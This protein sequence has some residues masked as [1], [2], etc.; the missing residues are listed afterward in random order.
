MT[1][2]SETGLSIYF[3]ADGLTIHLGEGHRAEARVMRR[4]DRLLVSPAL[5]ASNL[6]R[7]QTRT[8]FELSPDEQLARF[9]KIHFLVGEPPEDFDPLV[10]GSAQAEAAYET[11]RQRLWREVADDDERRVLLAKLR[12]RFQIGTTSRTLKTYSR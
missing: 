7:D 12:D 5:R 10:P 3:V 8:V 1:T 6:G 2:T 11:E 4:G 9:G